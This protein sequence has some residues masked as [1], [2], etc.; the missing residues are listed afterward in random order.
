MSIAVSAS[1]R[2]SRIL[3]ASVTA[4]AAMGAA[5]A[6]GI[7]AGLIGEL[8]LIIRVLTGFTFLFLSFFGFY[9]GVRFRKI[10]QLDIDGA[11]RIRLSESSEK[12]AC[13][14][15]DWPHV[16]TDK[17]VMQLMTGSTLWPC[18]LLLRLHA[19][20]HSVRVVPILPDSVSRESFRALSVAVRW[21]ARQ[22]DSQESS[23]F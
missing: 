15:S 11:G 7:M 1:I 14:D 4:M 3:F 21:I 2:P 22:S 6:M 5:I 17:Q 8:S 20:D 12:V 10:L 16:G 19:D 18:L 9:H 23:L 13:S